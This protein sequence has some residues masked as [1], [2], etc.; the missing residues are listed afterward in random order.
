MEFQVTFSPQFNVKTIYDESI[1]EL[2][3]TW[4]S[5]LFYELADN[6]LTYIQGFINSNSHREG[7]T[8]NLARSIKLYRGT[9]KELGEIS[10]GIGLISEMNQLAPYWYL[11]NFGG[12]T[13][14][15]K[16]GRG[17]GGYFDGEEPPD[18]SKR[19]TNVGTDKFIQARNNFFMFPKSP[20]RPM[21]YIENTRLRLE[22]QIENIIKSGTIFGS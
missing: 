22:F 4:L 12:L 14:I 15:A 6:M 7:Q 1:G 9:F 3:G 8:G 2:A 11:I 19:G 18:K 20:I 16:E 10:W 21:N 5:A 17:V 13:T